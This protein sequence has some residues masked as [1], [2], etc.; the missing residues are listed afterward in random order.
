[1]TPVR[2]WPDQGKQFVELRGFEPLTSSMPWKRATNC[3]KAPRD[4]PTGPNAFEILPSWPGAEKL[5]NLSEATTWLRVPPG[6]TNGRSGRPATRPTRARPASCA[7]SDVPTPGSGREPRRNLRST[8]GTGA[9]PARLRRISRTHR[10]YHRRQRDRHAPPPPDPRSWLLDHTASVS[11]S[12]HVVLGD[13]PVVAG[14]VPLDADPAAVVQAAETA[15]R[16]P[17][18]SRPAGR[19]RP[20]RPAR[21]SPRP[22]SNRL[23][24]VRPIS[25]SALA[26]RSADLGDRL[27]G[28]RAADVLAPPGSALRA[29]GSSLDDLVARS[30]PPRSRRGSPAAA[31]GVHRQSGRR[32]QR[33]R[34]SGGPGTGRWTTDR[35]RAPARPAPRRPAAACAR[36][37]SSS[38][39]VGLALEP[40]GRVPRR[41]P[42][43]QHD[44]LAGRH[45]RSSTTQSIRGQSCHSRSRA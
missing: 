7:R 13:P 35:R 38:A 5:L 41:P 31:V 20:G 1:M 42:V 39:D 19:R 10:R 23:R 3:A 32:G 22:P 4:G 44:Q 2:F 12:G 37:R 33:R 18:A 30:A 40:A 9:E 24:T 8:A 11:G 16:S 28:R 34:P 17:P 14:A 26:T 45:R 25:A 6:Q 36:P 27:P 15:A 21:A 29:S 43:P